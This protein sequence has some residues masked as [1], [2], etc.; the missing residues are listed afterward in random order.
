MRILL[1]T[2]AYIAG[3]IPFGLVIARARGVD[4]RK[5]GSGNIG[6]TNVL[7]SVGKGSAILTLIGDMGK[8]AAIVAIARAAGFNDTGVGLVGLCA[9]LG[10]DF[11]V[12]LSFKGGKGVA[13]SLGVILVYSPVVGLATLG[14]W[15]LTA[16]IARYSSL[17]AIVSFLLLPVNYYLLSSSRDGIIRV[18]FGAVIAALILFKHRGNVSRLIDGTEGKIGGMSGKKAGGKAC[19]KACRKD[20]EEVQ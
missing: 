8:G 16:A 1:M 18:V 5:T 10:H 6:A 17:S 12:F 3:S 11:S 2:I 15:L 14:L 7:R 9:V 4:L 20:G 19:G 13:T